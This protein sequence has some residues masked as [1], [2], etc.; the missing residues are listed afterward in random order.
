VESD[1]PFLPDDVGSAWTT[2]AQVDVAGINSMEKTLILGECKWTFATVDRDVLA[3]LVESKVE[4]IV[5][6][7]GHWRL[8]LLGFSRSGWTA[9]AGQYQRWVQQQKPAGKNWQVTGMRLLDLR[10]VDMDLARWSD[11]PGGDAEEIRI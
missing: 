9:E 8:Y 10:Q 7:Q 4:R 11:E 5:P 2:E 6:S 1:L 3:A